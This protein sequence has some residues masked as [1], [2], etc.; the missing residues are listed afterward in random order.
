MAVLDR[1]TISLFLNQLQDGSHDL[2]GNFGEELGTP[3][4]EVQGVHI[5][6]VLLALIHLAFDPVSVEVPEKMVNVLGGNSVPVPFSDVVGQEGFVAMGLGLFI[7]LG[8]V[9]VQV[10]FEFLVEILAE[11]VRCFSVSIIVHGEGIWG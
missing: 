6:S 2:V 4:E 1:L 9:V 7:E 8:E 11:K 5:I 3:L 10:L